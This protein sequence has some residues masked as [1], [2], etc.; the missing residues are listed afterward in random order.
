[1]FLFKALSSVS[2]VFEAGVGRLED[3]ESATQAQHC[4]AMDLADPGL[5]DPEHRADLLQVQFL[6]V[7]QRQHQ[8][9]ALG[10]QADRMAQFAAELAALC[11]LYTS[12]AADE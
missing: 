12:D 11:L 1:M 8:L 3:L 10:Q 7:V 5:A 2:V 4:L 9:F 6:L